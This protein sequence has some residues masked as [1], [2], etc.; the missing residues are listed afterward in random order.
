MSVCLGSSNAGRRSR[1]ASG[2]VYFEPDMEDA[3]RCAKYRS[4]GDYAPEMSG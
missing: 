2:A 4:I 1:L 3:V